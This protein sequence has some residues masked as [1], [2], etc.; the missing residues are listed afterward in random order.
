MLSMVL[1]LEAGL[2]QGEDIFRPRGLGFLVVSERFKHFV[3]QH[4]FTNMRLTPIEEYVWNPLG[5]EPA[6][7]T[8]T[9]TQ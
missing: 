4:G 6:S 1:R 7:P 5:L 8:L 9:S 2:W 3:K